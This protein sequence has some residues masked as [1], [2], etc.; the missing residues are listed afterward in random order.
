MDLLSN[1]FHVNEIYIPDRR[2]INVEYFVKPPNNK[3]YINYDFKHF[4]NQYGE[5]IGNELYIIKSYFI[6]LDPVPYL[7]Y[8]LYTFSASHFYNELKY[9][10]L[11]IG[12][13]HD[14]MD[15]L[16]F[17]NYLTSVIFH[18][19]YVNYRHREFNYKF[20][21]LCGNGDPFEIYIS[22]AYTCHCWFCG[23]NCPECL[24]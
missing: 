4:D 10:I 7:L 1:T 14:C 2:R 16:K 13:P 19:R 11:L 5:I 20:A 17:P 12:I 23:C 9:L 6:Y 22:S 21:R 15:N 3:I 8:L 18:Y 24:K